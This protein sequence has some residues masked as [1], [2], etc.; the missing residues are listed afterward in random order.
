MD[1]KTLSRKL[2]IE[3]T[4]RISKTSEDKLKYRRLT[5]S[6]YNLSISKLFLQYTV[7]VANGF[8]VI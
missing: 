8:I 4:T 3:Q 5:T 1:H 7:K 2:T 6:D